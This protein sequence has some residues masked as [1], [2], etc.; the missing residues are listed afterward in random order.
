MLL[1]VLE[2]LQPRPKTVDLGEDNQAAELL[3]ECREVCISG[4]RGSRGAAK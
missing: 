3:N 4:K 2:K 1:Q